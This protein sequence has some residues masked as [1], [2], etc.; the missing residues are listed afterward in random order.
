[1]PEPAVESALTRKFGLRPRS[2]WEE[3]LPRALGR[4]MASRGVTHR[5]QLPD[6]L[7]CADVGL[8]RELAGHLTVCE[9]FFFRH[10][11]QL[12]QAVEHI[13]SELGRGRQQVTLW[14][15][16]CSTGEEP[17]SVRMLL[18]ERLG[19]LSERVKIIACDISRPALTA[20]DRAVYGDWSLRGVSP[21]LI[22]RYFSREA[23][24]KRRVGAAY[25]SGIE[26]R[27]LSIL[28]TAA[29]LEAESVEVVLFRNVGV[30]LEPA[31][32]DACHAAFA[33]IL[34][35][36]GLLIQAPTD[37]VPPRTEFRRL[38]RSTASLYGRRGPGT[39]AGDEQVQ[40]QGSATKGSLFPHVGPRAL[41]PWTQQIVRQQPFGAGRLEDL[42]E[43]PLVPPAT[44]PDERTAQITR[45]GN[46]GRIGEALEHVETLLED[47]PT[48]AEGYLLRAQLH[49]AEKHVDRAMEDLRRVLFI[50]PEHR[51]GRYWYAVVLQRLGRT[52]QVLGQLRELERQLTGADAQGV[53]ED[54]QTTSGD[55]LSA[56][57]WLRTAT[58]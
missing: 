25:R 3:E 28:E 50:A 54:G 33:R 40:A 11:E 52:A 48:C 21:E 22:E 47:D 30:Y 56:V 18:A 46:G 24:G 16:G 42:L 27:H 53:L 31:A 41:V 1:M 10:R 15:A 19:T 58:E 4:V 38:E 5:T 36:G 26:F 6:E 29:Q 12:D 34:R 55:L 39:P 57:A 51:I 35:V 13:D 23:G 32:N 45:L 8:L 37:P 49:L 14:S 2:S 44:G 7:L 20:A 43:S 17:Y 9:T